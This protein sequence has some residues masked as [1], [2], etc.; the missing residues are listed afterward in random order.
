MRV[1]I[2]GRRS[3]LTVLAP[4]TVK[5]GGRAALRVRFPKAAVSRLAGRRATVRVKITLATGGKFV[6]RTVA[7][8][9]KGGLAPRIFLDGLGRT[10]R[11]G[12]ATRT[13]G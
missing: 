12:P 11:A 13:S 3:T 10:H 6:S 7:V 5:A 2:A 1:R 4:K 8:V 9:V